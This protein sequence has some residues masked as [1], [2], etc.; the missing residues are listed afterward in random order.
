[1][2]QAVS[3][4]S[5]CF[6]NDTLLDPAGRFLLLWSNAAPGSDR[7]NDFQKMAALCRQGSGRS[8]IQL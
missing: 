2:E 8:Q 5:T 7:W 1:M 4:T 6:D 3:T